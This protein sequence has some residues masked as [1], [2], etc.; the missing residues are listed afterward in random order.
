MAHMTQGAKEREGGKLE[1]VHAA[2][3][4]RHAR[5]RGGGWRVRRG[6]RE[7]RD[8]PVTRSQVGDRA[9]ACMRAVARA[10]GPRER[11]EGGMEI[12]VK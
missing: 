12:P 9:D 2:H 5:E 8:M 7:A 3:P 10:E 11:Y 6:A 4:R 1:P